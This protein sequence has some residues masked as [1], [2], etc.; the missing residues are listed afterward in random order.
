[1]KSFLYW[2]GATILVIALLVGLFLTGDFI[3]A[4]HWSFAS[5]WGGFLAGLGLLVLVLGRT[6]PA[7]LWGVSKASSELDSRILRRAAWIPTIFG[8]LILLGGAGYALTARADVLVGA[9]VV[10]GLYL[11]VALRR[12]GDSGHHD[13]SQGPAA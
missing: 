2:T 10:A 5:I 7:K 9:F 8:A 11:R 12:P 6:V 13:D 1:M 4:K 3:A